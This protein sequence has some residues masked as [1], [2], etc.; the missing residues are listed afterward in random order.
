MYVRIINQLQDSSYDPQIQLLCR[1][2]KAKEEDR[3]K[4]LQDQTDEVSE[5][6]TG[7]YN[8]WRSCDSDY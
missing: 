8:F 2:H 1:S 6:A 5:I 7:N 3:V 4:I